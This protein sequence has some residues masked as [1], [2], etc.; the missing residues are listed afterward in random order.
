MTKFAEVAVVFTEHYI[1]RADLMKYGLTASCFACDEALLG[2]TR[3]GGV[4]HS[5]Q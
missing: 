5:D 2:G 1:V 3:R 4:P